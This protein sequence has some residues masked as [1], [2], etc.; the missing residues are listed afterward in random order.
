MNCS[1]PSGPTLRE[2]EKDENDLK[3]LFAA[4]RKQWISAD[5]DSWLSSQGVYQQA[6]D[7]V[8]LLATRSQK[9]CL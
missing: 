4:T 3:E 9:V 7:A 2:L 8:K 5:L 6:V 1:I